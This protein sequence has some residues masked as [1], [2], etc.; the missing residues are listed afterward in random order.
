MQ[1]LHI[2]VSDKAS[3]KGCMALP[4]EAVFQT[5]VKGDE[6]RFTLR[7]QSIRTETEAYECSCK[8]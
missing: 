5:R 7:E 8:W 3:D 4:L 1:H 6:W 2:R